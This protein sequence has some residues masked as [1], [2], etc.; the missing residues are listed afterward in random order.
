MTENAQ[1]SSPDESVE[2]ARPV[3]RPRVTGDVVQPAPVSES[4]E[5]P[6]FLEGLAPDFRQ[7]LAT[8]DRR[9]DMAVAAGV[10]GLGS[11]LMVSSQE[12]RPGSIPDP[13]GSDGFPLIIGGF[14]I[15]VGVLLIVRRLVAW[16]RSSHQ[17]P[18]EGSADEAGFPASAVRPFALWGAGLAWAYLLP[19][20]GFI[21][22][23]F[24]LSVAGMFA[25]GVRS[26]WQLGVVP[27][28]FVIL[29]WALFARVF[30]LQFP[31]GPVDHFFE[32][33]IPRVSL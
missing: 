11:I 33:L 29:I 13:I 8:V 23:C 32:Q 7:P 2:A 18:T 25:M 16:R 30:G 20:L 9:I 4:A 15:F 1:Q 24:L 10:I 17:I 6:T 21:I 3:S 26:K 14:L 19:R 28:I 27:A 22:P 31:A 5:L 12:I